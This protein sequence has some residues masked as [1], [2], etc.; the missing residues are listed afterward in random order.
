MTRSRFSRL[1][2]P[3]KASDDALLGFC[4]LTGP[5]LRES[6]EGSRRLL[7]RFGRGAGRVGRPAFPVASA[8]SLTTDI[9]ETDPLEAWRAA[10]RPFPVAAG[11]GSIRG[12]PESR[13]LRR[14]S[15]D[16][17]L[18]PV[19]EPSAP[20]GTSPAPS[21]L[22]LEDEALE[23]RTLLDSDRSGILALAA[24]ALGA[25]RAVGLDLDA[26]AIFVARR[27]SGGMHSEGGGL[28]AGPSR[29]SRA[30]DLV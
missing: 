25:R 12:T 23:G 6:P 4:H 3:R 5:R 24:A 10:S 22:A 11:S 28:Y 14:P 7:P 29:L 17:L 30:V 19:G 27:T 1:L 16:A 26:D 2:I 15:P 18:L 13:R 20:A 8:T 21:P 9:V